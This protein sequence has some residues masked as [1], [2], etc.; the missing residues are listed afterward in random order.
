MFQKTLNP[1]PAHHFQ[2]LTEKVRNVALKNHS[3]THDLT[4]QPAHTF[5]SPVLREM[6]VITD[7]AAKFHIEI[8]VHFLPVFR[9]SKKLCQMSAHIMTQFIDTAC[10][11]NYP[12]TFKTVIL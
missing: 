6:S 2:L 11:L 12:L 9:T 3:L 8:F 10:S 4:Q 5:G 7:V 1:T